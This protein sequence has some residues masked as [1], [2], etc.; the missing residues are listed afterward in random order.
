MVKRL[1]ERFKKNKRGLEMLSSKTVTEL[2]MNLKCGNLTPKFLLFCIG[3][4]L[5]FSPFSKKYTLF[6]LRPAVIIWFLAIVI[7]IFK[8]KKIIDFPSL[9]RFL[10]F[11]FFAVFIS[12]FFSSNFYY[13]QK[14]FFYRFSLFILLPFICSFS[15]RKTEEIKFLFVLMMLGAVV[16]GVDSLYQLFKGVDFIHHYPLVEKVNGSSFSGLMGPFGW[17]TQLGAYSAFILTA[18]INFLIFSKEKFF[19]KIFLILLFFLIFFCLVFSLSRGAWVVFPLSLII[20]FFVV[21]LN[22][23]VRKEKRVR[24]KIIF[25]CII[26]FVVYFL[27]YCLNLREID[28]LNKEILLSGRDKIWKETIS[29]IIRYPLFGVGLYRASFVLSFHTDAHNAY[30]NLLLETGILGFIPFLLIIICY[31][32]KMFIFFIHR[33]IEKAVYILTFFSIC[34][35]FLINDLKEATILGGWD[36]GIFFWLSLGISLRGME[37]F[38]REYKSLNNDE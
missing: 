29:L 1:E 25:I 23:K 22:K 33:D 9:G 35:G 26:I 5:F 6:F 38:E 31:L 17:Y 2:K 7:L 16:V 24:L 37:L 10:I 18:I 20:I 13:S 36:L 34:L 4:S 30:L 21:S 14:L 27:M 28:F 32:K 19:Q 11:F 15:I 3:M 8:K 12:L